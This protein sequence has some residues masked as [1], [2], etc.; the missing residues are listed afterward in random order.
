MTSSGSELSESA[1]P[2]ESPKALRVSRFRLSAFGYRWLLLLPL[3][4]LPVVWLASNRGGAS[5]PVAAAQ[6]L[7]VETT[8]LQIESGYTASRTYT[9][10]LVARRSSDL[11]FERSGTVMA[12]LVDEGDVVN[13]G[14]PLAKLDV[15][16]LNAQRQQLE[17]QKRQLLAQLQELETGP[18]LEDISAAEAA[19]SDLRNQLDLAQLQAQR[20]ADLYAQGA[21]SR[22]E[23]DERRFGARAI[24]D[25]LTQ[26]QSQLTQLRNGTRQEQVTAQVAQ[27][28][29]IDA[30]LEAIDIALDK[31]I[32]F[33]PFTGEVAIRAIDEGTV[34]GNG[35]TAISL[36]ENGVVE[37]RIGLPVTVANTLSPGEPQSVKVGNRTYAAVVK[38]RLPAIDE[39][40]QT[41]TVV[42][43]LEAA[44]QA[45]MGETARLI[46]NEQQAATGYWLPSTALIAGDRGLWSVYVLGEPVSKG[47]TEGS[48][49]G[50]AEGY[51]VARRDVEMLHTQGNRVF[52]RGLVEA[53]DRVITS[54]T[55]RIVADQL[56]SITGE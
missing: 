6:L 42:L 21:V 51:R 45:V 50:N 48:T 7:P 3:T 5:E 24:A 56:V 22:E 19:V 46:V 4:L 39:A 10:E 43:E 34:V 28:D 9:G 41:V 47:R 14:A 18:R 15:R 36:V 20:R 32:L 1:L 29:Q 55:H 53:G 38:S 11:G 44:D 27:V 30:Q 2:Q 33:A 23:W 52:V 13:A 31:S 37:A 12:L 54:G 40:S 8:T 25:R 16:D 35:Q 49:E 26:A 17:A